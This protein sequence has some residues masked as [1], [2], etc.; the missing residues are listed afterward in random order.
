MQTL[1]IAQT[2]KNR[3]SELFHEQPLVVRSPG[4]VNI[5]GE[6]TDYNDGFVLPAAIDKAAYVAIGRRSDNNIRLFAEELDETFE[7][8]LSTLAPYDKG[9]PNYILGVADQ[10][11]K[12]GHSIG[13]FNLVLSGD[14]PIGAVLSSSAAIECATGFALNELFQTSISRLELVKM[15]QRAEHLFAGVRV[16]IMDMFASAFGKKDHVIK[17]DCRSLDYEY[18]PFKLEGIKIVLFN[19]NVEHSLASSEYNTRRQQCEAG[20]ALIRKHHPEVH[21][22]RDATMEMLHQYVEPV[23]ALIYKRCKYV[24]E[25]I[26]RLL[27]G[28]EDLKRGDIKAL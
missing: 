19:S 20:V 9:W 12:S 27:Q 16:G 26:G 10:F 18:V 6:H 7:S 13:G 15:A 25:E 8:S 22:L 1:P 4:R 23:N 2:V 21:S 3:Y 5:I 28:C 14:V 11:L 24:V 17:L